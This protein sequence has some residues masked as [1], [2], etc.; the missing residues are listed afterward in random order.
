[1][2][3]AAVCLSAIAGYYSVIGMASIFAGSATAVMLMTGTLEASKVIVAS[4][5]YNNWQKTPFLLKSYLTAAVVV[6][7]LI[8]SIGIFGYLSKAHIEQ[9]LSAQSNI[10]QIEKLQ[11]EI[12]RR[13]TTVSKLETEITKLESKSVDNDTGVQ[14][15]IDREQTRIDSA[16]TRIQPAIDEQNAI[17][18]QEEQR[19]AGGLSLYESQL[20]TIE[21]DLTNL[22]NYINANDIEKLQ[23]LVSVKVDGDFGTNTQVAVDQFKANKTLE[24]QRLIELIAKE[25]QQLVSP[26]IDA[27]REEIKRLRALAETEIANSNELINRLRSQIGTVSTS[28][29]STKI[30]KLEQDIAASNAAITGLIEQKTTLETEYRK[31]EA[32][33]GPI[34]FVAQMFYGETVTQNILEESVRYMIL[35]LIFVFDPLAMLMLIASNQGMREIREVWSKKRN[36][37]N[38]IVIESH[39]PAPSMSDVDF[40]TKSENTTVVDKKPLD[41][42]ENVSFT[43]TTE[44]EPIDQKDETTL[45]VAPTNNAPISDTDMLLDTLKTAHETR[46]QQYKTSN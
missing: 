12:N 18:A 19:L 34:K 29:V 33:V 1:M 23:A 11:E 7:M 22:Q 25:K 35:I 41:T 44:V 43:V 26:V 30:S 42:D 27:A 37:N 45:N 16:Y 36:T 32:E 2:F 4:W 9:T 24:Q 6:L 21:Q 3:I 38:V 20:Q 14:Q 40:T 39:N 15:Q 5:L 28:D 10:A 13:E 31:I 8:T 46:L 17:I